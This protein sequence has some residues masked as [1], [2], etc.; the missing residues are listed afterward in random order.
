MPLR[1]K[2][3]ATLALVRPQSEILDIHDWIERL[4]R[5]Q[6]ALDLG[7]GA[8]SFPD[9]GFACRIVALDEDPNAFAGAL[10]EASAGRYLRMVGRSDR[11]PCGDARFDLLICH[12]ALE[13]IENL[14]E[15]LSEMA[16]VLKPG[17]KCYFSFPNGYGLCD[18]I[19]RYVFEG[20]GHVNRFRRDAIVRELEERLHVGL[21]RWQKLHSSFVYLRR[22]AEL[23]EDP[24]RDLQKRLQ[25]IG[26]L[27]R[28]TIGAAQWM[29]YTGTRL[30]DCVFGT[31]LAVYGWALFFERNAAEPA[32][33]QPGYVNVCPFCGAGQPAA[34]AQRRWRLACR[35]GT[36][37]R[38][39]PFCPAFGNTI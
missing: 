24:P 17:G 10:R 20:G 34:S 21:V 36:C 39:Y 9:S 22:L 12:H 18:G 7:S 23:L 8:G 6:W 26:R 16:R 25:A 1:R 31:G 37:N 28:W 15:S 4:G 11:I 32:A 27:P 5:D 13:H 35:C 38:L 3:R 33:E 19:Y 30:I 14:D 2:R 29:L